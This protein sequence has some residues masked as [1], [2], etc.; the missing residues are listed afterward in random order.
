MIDCHTH[1]TLMKEYIEKHK[2]A[3][4]V[5]EGF[6]LKN[7]FEPVKNFYYHMDEAGIDKS[8]LLPI[9]TKNTF[10]Y[11][12]FDNEIID[13]I[14]RENERFIGFASVDPNSDDCLE[15]YEKAFHDLNLK[16][17]KLDSSI[18][19]FYPN[20]FQNKNLLEIYKKCEK[21]RIPIMFHCG[22]SPI[23]ESLTKYSYPFLLEEIVQ[24]FKKLN[25]IIAHFGWPWVLET[26]AMAIKYPNIF[27]DTS[28]LWAEKPRDFINYVFNG[29][30]RENFIEN[31]LR[32]KIIF[33]SN[34]P[35]IETFRMVKAIKGLKLSDKTF[36]LICDKNI[37]NLL[38]V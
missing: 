36:D 37:R 7:S 3:K 17:L 2:L 12:I 35:R 15:N 10:G 14:C 8:I 31:S 18:Q 23:K 5:R 20:D 38:E 19:Y 34:Y 1:P 29:Q 30:I 4:N 27:V 25:I 24:K 21:N 32:F 13:E 28:C 11:R 16:G 9:D 26:T 6:H 22:L 33:G